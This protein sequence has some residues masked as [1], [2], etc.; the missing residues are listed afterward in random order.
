MKTRYHRDG[1]V[2]IWS[3]HAQQ[4]VR[5]SAKDVFRD[6]QLMSTLNDDEKARIEAMAHGLTL[7]V[8]KRTARAI[9]RRSDGETIQATAML[10]LFPGRP[11][12]HTACSVDTALS[13]AGCSYA[14]RLLLL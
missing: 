13:A 2:T 11:K 14:A 12:M 6:D 4:W 10:D 9:I 8:A 3:T 5:A 1:D 7:S